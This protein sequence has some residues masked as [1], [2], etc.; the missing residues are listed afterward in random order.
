METFQAPALNPLDNSHAQG[1]L[2]A[3]LKAL[4]IGLF[5]QVVRS[6]ER[7]VNVSGSAHLGSFD[8]ISRHVKR[9]GLAI[10]H[11]NDEEAMRYLYRAW[12]GRNPKRGLA[13]MR[14]YLQLLFP[15]T[16]QADQLWHRKGATYPSA[17]ETETD[18]TGDP[19]VNYWLTSRIKVSIT[20]PDLSTTDVQRVLRPLRS[21]LGA[22]FVL[23]VDVTSPNT[24]ENTSDGQPLGLWNVVVVERLALFAGPL[25]GT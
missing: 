7:D 17:L 10:F 12:K 5:E 9:D 11:R 6:A 14:L 8:L 20:A 23:E 1:E 3:E 22:K 2:E 18:I 4:T 13:F 15:N 24:I 25:S 19:G 21:T 16:W